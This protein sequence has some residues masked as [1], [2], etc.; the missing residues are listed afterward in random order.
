MTS[1]FIQKR[2]ICSQFLCMIVD[3]GCWYLVMESHHLIVEE[4]YSQTKWIQTYFILNKWMLTI[5]VNVSLILNCKTI[6]VSLF[7]RAIRWS[8]HLLLQPE[9]K[10]ISG[11]SEDD[12]FYLTVQLEPGRFDTK[13]FRYK[14][15]SICYTCKVDSIQTHVTW[16]CFDTEYYTIYKWLNEPSKTYS[17]DEH[18]P[19]EMKQNHTSA[20]L[21]VNQTHV[22][23]PAPQWEHAS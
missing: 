12:Y 6:S 18:K 3:L 16:S 21:R 17:L 11:S 15:K 13:S 23:K 1:R 9:R 22:P 14:S 4:N 8:T 2:I 5:V 19:L 20:N 7:K 10:S